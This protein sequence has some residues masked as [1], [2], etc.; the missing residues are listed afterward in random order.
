MIIGNPPYVEYSKVKKQ[1]AVI[2]YKTE[3]CGN[4]YAMSIERSFDL[5][6]GPVGM[7]V[8]LPLVCTD[9]MIPAQSLFKTQSRKSWF[10]NFDDRP[11]KLFDDLQHIRATI[12]LTTEEKDI[13]TTTLYSTKYN[14]WFTETR[15]TL[16]EGIVFE[17]IT[18]IC[19]E[20]AFPKIADSIG[21][22]IASKLRNA[23]K[24]VLSFKTGKHLCY[25]HNSPQYWVRATDFVPYFWN[26][27]DGEKIST[28]VKPLC[29][30]T[31]LDASIV[32]ATLN[33]SLF[34]WWFLV[35]S[36]CRD[37]TLREVRSFP[38]GVGQIDDAIKQVLSELTADLMQDLKHHAHRKE[39]N[40]KATGRVVYDEFYPRHSKPIIDKIDRVLAEHYGFTDEELDFIIN[41][42]IKYRMGL[43][44]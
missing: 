14:R 42:D 34:Y 15:S 10:A 39:T 20:G 4:L 17:D 24:S 28:H 36:N 37:L 7:I 22:N 18:D 16:F 12:F 13:E 11:G 1:Y 32:A 27:Q 6:K 38:I 23:K 43:G 25:F 21:R 31:E 8:Q 19:A 44:K 3:K 9:R 33:S 26:E 30:T 29:L 35:L 40:Y 41:Y 2:E 5:S